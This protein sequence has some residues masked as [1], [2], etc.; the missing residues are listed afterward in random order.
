MTIEE[1][2]NSFVEEQYA[3][4]SLEERQKL[5]QFFTPP[6][7]TLKMLEKLDIKKNDTLLDPCLGAGGLLAAAIIMKKVKPENCYGIELDADI[8]KIAQKRLSKLGVPMANLHHGNALNSQCYEF[9]DGYKY[10]AENDIVTTMQFSKSCSRFG[11]L[12]ARG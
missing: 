10:D 2:Y 9:K 8:L 3:G 6:E 11:Q 7:L 4:K 1:E 5:G 12:R